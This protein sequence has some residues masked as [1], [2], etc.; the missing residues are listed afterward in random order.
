MVPGVPA[1][2]PVRVGVGA[3]GY[4]VWTRTYDALPSDPIRVLLSPAP[5]GLEGL[6]EHVPYFFQDLHAKVTTDLGGVR[7]LSVSGYLNSE[8]LRETD[9]LDPENRELAMTWWATP[10]FRLTTA[11]GSGRHGSSTPTWDIAGSRAI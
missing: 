6:D 9:A 8:S 2:G 7:R 1:A 11:T 10:P 5:V 3:F 4:A